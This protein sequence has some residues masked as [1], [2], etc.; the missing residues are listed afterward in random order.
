[1][2]VFPLTQLR[3]YFGQ[4][5]RS[6]QRRLVLAGDSTISVKQSVFVQLQAPLLRS[7]AYPRDVRLAARKMMQRTRER[8]IM[9]HPQ[10]RAHARPQHYTQPRLTL[11]HNFVHFSVP[12]KC[13]GQPV[14]ILRAG[15]QIHIPVR[16][17]APPNRSGHGQPVCLVLQKS[18][19]GLR[20][21]T[22]V[23]TQKLS[24]VLLH[25][26]NSV[27]DP[28]GSLPAESAHRLQFSGIACSGQRIYV[29]YAQFF[30]NCAHS[31]G[32]QTGNFRHLHQSFGNGRLQFLQTRQT[33]GLHESGNASRQTLADSSDR[34]QLP[35]GS[36]RRHG[37]PQR[38]DTPGRIGVRPY[39]KST[40]AVQ[41]HQCRHLLQDFRD[42]PVVHN[43]L[44]NQIRGDDSFRRCAA[45]PAILF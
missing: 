21:F 32:P 36:Q 10:I 37:F 14:R 13:P 6:E 8:L 24:P 33:P 7:V 41:L 3:G 25:I 12:H 39:A 26:L 29:H 28:V 4:T 18:P 22:S 5:Q 23:M 15:D 40:L 45:T 31:L 9:Y 44:H 35:L 27:R 2:L 34:I 42:L 11:F 30:V 1:M 38:L 17:R 19:N 20:L 16:F 43:F